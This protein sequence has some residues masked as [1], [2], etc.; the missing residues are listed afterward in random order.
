LPLAAKLDIEIGDVL[1]LEI[2][3]ICLPLLVPTMTLLKDRLVGE[4]L[5]AGETPPVPVPER[6]TYHGLN[7]AL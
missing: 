1:L 5:R 6:A 7:E 2:V 4:N 3:T